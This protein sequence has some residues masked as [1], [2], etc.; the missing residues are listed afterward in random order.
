VVDASYGRLGHGQL[1][2]EQ[3]N[4]GGRCM[5]LGHAR[6]LGTVKIGKV[7]AHWWANC[8]RKGELSCSS[9]KIVRYLTWKVGSNF[10]ISSSQNESKATL[11]TF[12]RSLH[13]V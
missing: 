8:G 5:N 1:A 12:S 2:L 3:N 4:S 7:T 10:Y 13:S 9:N 6:S 11:V